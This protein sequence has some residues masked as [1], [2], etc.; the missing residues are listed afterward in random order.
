MGATAPSE[1]FKRR[2]TLFGPG[3]KVRVGRPVGEQQS[4]A[5]EQ[6]ATTKL[7]IS[8]PKTAAPPAV[9]EQE[10]QPPPIIL[11]SGVTQV[12]G[13]L[14]RKDEP[15]EVAGIW[16]PTLGQWA[17]LSAPSVT[18]GAVL[19]I[20]RVHVAR[21]QGVTVVVGVDKHQTPVAMWGVRS[22]QKTTSVR[23]LK[24]IFSSLGGQLDEQ[25]LGNFKEGFVLYVER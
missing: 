1:S 8:K 2:P 9:T 15:E 20:D 19:K 18:A 6:Q 14:L 24:H 25:L 11:P 7:A 10:A 16:V 21:A 22:P 4:P 13:G 17:I 12:H 5:P 3:V 23:M